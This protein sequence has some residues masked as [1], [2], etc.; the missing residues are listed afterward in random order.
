MAMLKLIFMHLPMFWKSSLGVSETANEMRARRPNAGA[1][2]GAFTGAMFVVKRQDVCIR[3]CVKFS[4]CLTEN[5]SRQYI[6][7]TVGESMTGANAEPINS[8]WELRRGTGRPVQDTSSFC[9]TLRIPGEQ[10][11]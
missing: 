8:A 2:T 9:S 10:K 5:A 4:L 11:V 3:G 6:Y 1:Q 7:S